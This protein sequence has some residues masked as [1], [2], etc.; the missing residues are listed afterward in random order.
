[1]PERRARAACRLLQA[2]LL[3]CS[4]APPVAAS[5]TLAEQQVLHRG[6]A[7]EPGTLDPHRSEGVPSGNILRDLFEGLTT[8]APDGRIVPGVARHWSVSD[9]GLIYRFELRPQ[10]RWSNGEPLTAHDFVYSFRR[11]VDPATGS[12]YSKVFEPIRNAAAIIAGE[13]GPEALGITALDEH[14]LEIRLAHPAPYLLELLA[15]PAFYPVHR[16]SLERWGEAFARPGRLIGNGAYTLSEWVIQSRI[17]LDRNPHYWNDAAT[18]IDTVYYYPTE[19]QAAEFKR[20]RAGEL[21]WTDAIPKNQVRWIREHLPDEFHV[22]PYLGTYYYGLNLRREPFRDHPELRRAL[23]LAI[24]RETLT[25][26]LLGSGEIPA[27]G[28][29]PPG[30]RHYEPQRPAWADWSAERRLAEARRLYRE[31]GYSAERPLQVELR[32]NTQDDHRKIAIAVAYMWR[33]ALGVQTRLLNEEWKVFL[34]NRRFGK[35]TQVFR[36]AWI[37]DYNDAYSFLELFIGDND[38]NDTGY[39]NARYDGLLREAA[40]EADIA[41]RAERM[42]QAERQLLD[43]QPIIPIY[44]YVSARLVKPTVRGWQPN[45]LDHHYTRSMYLVRAP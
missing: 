32:Y 17:R 19:N 23:A 12:N 39:A 13:A 21:H 7:A 25:G 27:W 9:D 24:D 2:V 37:G 44:H 11:S 34:Q 41:R 22:S 42:Q 6:N 20:Y 16:P 33:R 18:R 45:V 15:H 36:A 29:V 8:E 1:M 35:I 28:W 14:R 10:A 4:L 3:S 31:A 38:L 43:D 30:V 5:D 40:A 26:K